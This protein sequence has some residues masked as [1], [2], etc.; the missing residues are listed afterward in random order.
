ML[1]AFKLNKENERFDKTSTNAFAGYAS[2]E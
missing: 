1:R 2:N